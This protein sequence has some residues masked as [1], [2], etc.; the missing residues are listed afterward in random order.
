MGLR[1]VLNIRLFQPLPQLVGWSGDCFSWL[2]GKPAFL[3][4][5]KIRESLADSWIFDG[6]KA[7]GQFG[8]QP[9]IP[10]LE[11]FEEVTLGYRKKGWL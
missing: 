11:K 1:G 6:A 7:A 10:L 2:T 5:D 4:S 3:N 9:E 8:F